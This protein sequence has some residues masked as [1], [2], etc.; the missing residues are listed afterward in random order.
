M[1][2]EVKEDKK[3]FNY[4][5]LFL[6][7]IIVGV[8]AFLIG[9]GGLNNG[10]TGSSV[11]DSNCKQVEEKYQ[12]PY[13]EQEPY[14]AIEEETVSLKYRVESATAFQTLHGFD[15]YER[16]EV[17]VRNIDDETGAFTVE[18]TFTT[19]GDGPTTLRGSYQILSAEAIT[20]SQDY[21]I[22]AG[23]DV[24]WRYNVLPGSKIIQKV[25]TKYRDVTRYKEAIRTVEK[26]D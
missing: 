4:V 13:T 17:V 20:F 21:D 14:Q 19:L 2:N 25:V 10:P 9:K 3:K 11:A 6:L 8:V 24:N 5:Y 1:V 18:Q 7:I 22:N 12:E 16:G 15:V 23:E 26:C